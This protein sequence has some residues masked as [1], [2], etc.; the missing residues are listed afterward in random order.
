MAQLFDF[1]EQLREHLEASEVHFAGFSQMLDAAATQPKDQL[2]K[3]D[4]SKV[5]SGVTDDKDGMAMRSSIDVTD[6]PCNKSLT[7]NELVL[8]Y[9]Q[10]DCAPP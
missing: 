3:D 8:G 2:S 1:I 10:P 7:L 4:T 5:P 6:D 9:D